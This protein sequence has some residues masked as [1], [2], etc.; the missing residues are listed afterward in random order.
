MTVEALSNLLLAG[1]VAVF[2]AEL[3]KCWDQL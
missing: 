1:M 2:L 3:K